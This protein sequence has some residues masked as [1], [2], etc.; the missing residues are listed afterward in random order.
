MIVRPDGDGLLLLTQEQHAH[1]SG[2]LAAR[3]SEA[4]DP[5]AELVRGA[6]E[7][8]NGWREFDERP[9]LSVAGGATPYS[10]MP[11]D[12][13][14]AIWRR[15]VARASEMGEY[16]GLLVS[17]HGM[18]M[19]EKRTDPEDRAFYAEER[20]RENGMLA[21]LRIGGSWEA[22]P[23][24]VRRHSAWI[25]FLD[26]LTLLALDGWKSPWV[27]DHDGL[28]RIEARR[29]GDSVFVAPWPFDA[30]TLVF[31]LPA[32]RLATAR[33]ADQEA[34]DAA[35]RASTERLIEVVYQAPATEAGLRSAVE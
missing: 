17:L 19:F 34:L 28:G 27:T 35:W 7:H 18:R 26:G 31:H 10:Q 20:A 5:R 2:D 24:P 21:S 23:E 33:F 29:V 3:L 12:E 15:G 4:P 9:R 22:L 11:R 16:V 13:Y 6:R 8:D 32:R 30:P 14:R 25:A 1:L